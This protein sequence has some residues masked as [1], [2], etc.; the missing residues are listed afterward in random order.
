MAF[1]STRIAHDALIDANTIAGDNWEEMQRLLGSDEWHTD[2][3]ITMPVD[4]MVDEDL[5]YA[6]FPLARIAKLADSKGMSVQEYLD[7]VAFRRDQLDCRMNMGSF[8]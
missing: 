2:D 3:D 7:D 1:D 5:S 4:D 8:K 6:E